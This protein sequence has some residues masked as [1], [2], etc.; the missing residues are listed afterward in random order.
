MKQTANGTSSGKKSLKWDINII[1]TLHPQQI[2]VIQE[3]LLYRKPLS[4]II[5]LILLKELES[6]LFLKLWIGLA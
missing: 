4:M 6:M 5:K 1:F 2:A 3:M